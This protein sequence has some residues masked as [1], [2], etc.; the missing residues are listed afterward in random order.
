[1]KEPFDWYHNLYYG[2]KRRLSDYDTKNPKS[3]D[4][5]LKQLFMK[6]KRTGKLKMINFLPAFNAA[7]YV[8]VCLANTKGLDEANLDDE[9]DSAIRSIWGEDYM[10]HHQPLSLIG[11]PYVERMLIQWMVYA[12]LFLQEKHSHE[13]RIFLKMF[14]IKLSSFEYDEELI[15]FEEWKKYS[16]L[17]DLPSMIEQWEYRYSTD[18]Q[19]HPKNPSSYKND[20]WDNYVRYYGFDDLI[21]QLTFFPTKEEQMAFLNW[22][23]IQSSRPQPF[24]LSDQLPF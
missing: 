7:Y 19:P 2:E 8:A 4:Y 18:F 6:A 1:M 3:L 12:I 15:N 23:R 14:K 10:R 20:I 24:M 16:F 13:M 21:C 22:A 17:L 9:I 5:L 11:C